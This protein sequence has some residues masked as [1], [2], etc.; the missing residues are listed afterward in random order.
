[1]EES[2]PELPLPPALPSSPL[3]LRITSRSLAMPAAFPH[4]TLPFLPLAQNFQV[5][6]YAR[7]KM[8]DEEFRELIASSLTCRIDAR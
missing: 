1:M 7:S 4:T 2:H 8:T 3:P 5:F 6:G